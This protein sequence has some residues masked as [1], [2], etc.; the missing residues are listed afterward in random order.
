VSEKTD[1]QT[2]KSTVFKYGGLSNLN[3]FFL[4]ITPPVSLS[5]GGN[6]FLNAANLATFHTLCFFC[7]S[8]RIP[9]VAFN[10]SESYVN[11]RY[12]KSALERDYDQMNVEFYIDTD[13]KVYKFLDNWMKAIRNPRNNLTSYPDD[14]KSPQMDLEIGVNQKDYKPTKIVFERG[15]ITSLG[16]LQLDWESEN[17]LMIL[18]VTFAFDFYYTKE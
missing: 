11:G 13:L 15:F 8:V 3:T 9:S 7:K 1:L 4:H 14:Y 10:L 5:T 6:L 2:F 17:Q 16:E 18:P 12:Y